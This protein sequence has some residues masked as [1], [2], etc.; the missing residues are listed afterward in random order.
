MGRFGR[1]QSRTHGRARS[2]DMLANVNAQAPTER[3]RGATMGPYRP[4]HPPP[5]N[6][7]N[8]QTYVIGEKHRRAS[9]LR[10]N[11]DLGNCMNKVVN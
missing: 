4:T 8:T 11:M 2:R 1:A 10:P 7:I 5:A 6:P 3:N 9:S